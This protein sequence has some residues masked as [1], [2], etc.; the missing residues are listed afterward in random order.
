MQ[1]PGVILHAPIAVPVTRRR[2]G[3][4]PSPRGFEQGGHSRDVEVVDE[5]FV[6]NAVLGGAVFAVL[7]DDGV[8]APAIGDHAVTSDDAA[9]AVFSLVAV[10]ED[11]M[12]H[13][14]LQDVECVC[15]ILEGDPDGGGFVGRDGDLE[16]LD[17]VLLH[18]GDVV[19]WV[20]LRDKGEDGLQAEG[21]QVGEVAAHGE[22]AAVD[23]RGDL[24][25]VGD[26][27]RGRGGGTAVF[28]AE[29]AFAGFIG[30]HRRGGDEGAVGANDL[31]AGFWV[32]LGGA[33]NGE[34]GERVSSFMMLFDD[35]ARMLLSRALEQWDRGR[36]EMQTNEDPDESLERPVLTDF[37]K[38]SA[39]ERLHDEVHFD[40]WLIV[41]WLLDGRNVQASKRSRRCCVE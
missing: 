13:G 15:D 41:I 14:V 7:G 24:G 1:S 9:R 8:G 29:T 25:K 20:F 4:H 36:V 28:D 3:Q 23:A 10:H 5:G 12:H 27:T 18:E 37:G 31:E 30:G 34:T 22:G 32:H 16:M 2:C 39:G 21:A 11:G 33:M 26:K 35:M 19:Q 40:C 6:E 38:G 17:A